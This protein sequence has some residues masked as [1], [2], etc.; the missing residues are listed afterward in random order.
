[1]NYDHDDEQTSSLIPPGRYRARAIDAGYGTSSKGTEQVAILFELLDPP[2][3]GQSRTWYGYFLED[4][5]DK[6]RKTQAER[7]VEAMR[8]CG[9]TFPRGDLTNFE[10]LGT[11]EISITI[12]HETDDKGVV[13]DRIRFVNAPGAGLA[14][15]NRMDDAAKKSF[16]QRF[17][18][19]ALASAPAGGTVAPAKTPPSTGRAAPAGRPSSGAKAPPMRE[20][21]DDSFDPDMPDWMRD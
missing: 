6:G 3:Q 20:P 5:R 7:A 8:V 12:Q 16:A 2:Y 15:G 9:C 18:G 17:R 11:T 4:K 14:L 10:G 13:R 19:L 21:G 1:M